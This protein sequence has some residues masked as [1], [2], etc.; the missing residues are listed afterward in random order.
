MNYTC[1]FSNINKQVPGAFYIFLHA[2]ILLNSYAL[3][4]GD[5]IDFYTHPCFITNYTIE[6]HAGFEYELKILCNDCYAPYFCFKS[7]KV[8]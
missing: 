1:S 2:Q 7:L 6:Q 3:E 5:V 8:R 4:Y